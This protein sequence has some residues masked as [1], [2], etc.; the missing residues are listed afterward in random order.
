MPLPNLWQLYGLRASPFFQ[1]TL[2]ARSE[3]Y[4]IHLF[5]GRETE[6]ARALAVIGG[7][8]SSRQAIAGP[9]G[10]GKTTFVQ[11]LKGAALEA[12]YWTLDDIVPLYVGD[13]V[14]GLIGRLLGAVYGAV[15][16]ARPRASGAA[17]EAAGQL[18]RAQRIS[19]GG[20]S[21]SVLGVGGGFT[22]SQSASTPP[23][24]LQLDGPRV[25][26]DLL[27]YAKKQGAPGVLVHLNNLENLGDRDARKAAELL[28][29]VRDPILL[30][31]GLHIILVGAGEVVHR[32]VGR[33]PQV[34]S[35]FSAPQSLGPLDL[36]ELRAL[37]DRRYAHLSLSARK[38]GHAPVD[39]ETLTRVYP[40]FRG[41]LRAFLKVIEDGV[42]ALLGVA[43]RTPP[44]PIAYGE[45]RPVLQTI[46]ARQLRTEVGEVRYANLAAWAR[47]DAARAR[48][49]AELQRLW[50]LT[51]GTVSV[52]LRSLQ[53]AGCVEALPRVAGKP[54]QWLLAGT[55]RIALG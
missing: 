20:A 23:G 18:V 6:R 27:T 8:G 25:L 32:V 3:R 11:S 50:G 39:D 28:R 2:G 54:A 5:V 51:Q 4:P 37:L 7:S 15:V 24:A 21:V 16:A 52:A 22:R 53:E 41:D 13:D 47:R 9:P 45:L 49:Q 1:E 34:R 36:D 55:A 35:I 31:E 42:T 29:S 48:T 19:G 33:Y 17:V 38:R 26:R 44:A 30:L 10:I 14:E 46:T 43:Q 12:G 40:L